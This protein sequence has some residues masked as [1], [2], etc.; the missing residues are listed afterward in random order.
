MSFTPRSAT[1]IRQT[2]VA[3]IVATSKLTDVA[4]GGVLGT[5]AGNV[6]EEIS[7]VERRYQDFVDGHFFQGVY[8]ADLDDRIG[9]LPPGFTP[10]RGAQ[11]ASGGGLYITRE[12]GVGA[13]VVPAGGILVGRSDQPNLS[14]TNSVAF[15]IADAQL[16]YPGLGDNAIRL[17]CTT[18]GTLGNCGA[19]VIDTIL[20]ADSDI[21]AVDNTELVT[22]A[23]DGE[24]DEELRSRAYLWVASLSSCQPTALERLA[25][26]FTGSDGTSLRHAKLYED[27]DRPGYSELVVSDAAGLPAI[28]RSANPTSGTVPTLASGQRYTFYFDSPAAN[29]NALPTFSPIA[30]TVTKAGGGATTTYRTDVGTT[31]LPVEERGV[32]WVARDTTMDIAAGD[33]W[34]VSGHDVYVGI[35]AELQVYLE[36]RARAAGTRVRVVAA[37]RQWLALAGTVAVKTGFTPTAVFAALK[38]EIEA[39][40]AT[41]GPGEPLYMF[42]LYDAL[43]RVAGV[44]NIVLNSGDKYPQSPRHK[45][46][47]NTSGITLQ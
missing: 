35:V 13:I 29:P 34:S 43:S 47:I 41:L 33:A 8:G 32:L 18:P 42:R 6:A 14:Y 3:R 1:E 17:V 11:P 38:R 20:A 19:H 16:T 12:L 15:T 40:V 4:E 46:V 45:L 25:L 5:I 36:D 9:Q 7:A 44:T 21:I 39:Y 27:P 30:L 26:N 10:R 37:I 22:G 2:L 23:T 31:F 24:T 28:T